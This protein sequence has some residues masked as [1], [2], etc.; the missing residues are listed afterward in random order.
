MTAYKRRKRSRRFAAAWDRSEFTDRVSVAQGAMARAVHGERRIVFRDS[1]P[2]KEIRTYRPGL[3]IHMLKANLPKRYTMAAWRRGASTDGFQNSWYE[4][5]E[6][7]RSLD[8]LPRNEK[9]PRWAVRFLDVLRETGSVHDACRVVGV[10]R[11][12]AY[13]LRLRAPLF[14]AFW[15]EIMG[16]WC[17]DLEEA[18]LDLATHGWEE[19]VFQGGNLVRVR[20]RF[21]AALMIFML[22]A[23]LRWDD[24]SIRA[25]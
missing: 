16:A 9:R 22:K 18:A 2:V 14:A 17:D 11:S 3:I 23:L 5:W 15:D 13:R 20:R 25:P 12:T 6:R 10:R 1:Y 7:L 24:G 8:S 19:R 21:S 4:A